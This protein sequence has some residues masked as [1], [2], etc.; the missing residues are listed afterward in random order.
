MDAAVD[1]ILIWRVDYRQGLGG[2]AATQRAT[3]ALPRL[4]LRTARQIRTAAGV[5]LY[6]SFVVALFL[7]VV[8]IPPLIQ[9]APRLRLIDVPNPRKVHTVPVPLCG[10][11]AIAAG[12]LVPVLMWVSLDR[13]ALAYLAG[14][15]TILAVGVYDDARP[16][17]Y[18]WKFAG[19]GVAVALVLAGGISLV[20]LP[21][22]GMDP[23]PQW[24]TW[25]VTALFIV[26]VTNAVNLADG[27][28]GL[29]GGCVLLTLLAVGLLAY[30]TDGALVLV[31]SAAMAGAVL[32][33]LRYNTHP[34]SV[35]LG[36]AGSMFLGFTSAVMAILLVERFHSAL[37]PALP[38]LLVGLPIMD[39][40][41]VFI[42]RLAAGQSPFVADRNHLHHQL[43][44]AGF[45]QMEA[46]SVI[47]LVQAAMVGM[48]LLTRYE[49]DAVV[50]AAFVAI[51]LCVTV[52]LR[53][54]QASGRRLH[55]EPP[56]GQFVE[57]RNTW[58]RRQVWLPSWSLAGVRYGLGAFLC[59]GALAPTAT[60]KDFAVLAAIAAGFWVIGTFLFK[61][62]SMVI[63]RMVMYL[64]AGFSAYLIAS[65]V[66]GDRML[67]WS[68]GVYLALLAGLLVIAIRVTRRELFR[69]TPQDLLILFLALAVPNLSG[70]D[71][72]RYY[73]REVAAI[74]VVLFY[75]SEFI[76]A[77]D[78][79]GRSAIGFA[80]AA[81]LAL[82]GVRG[83]I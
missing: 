4:A 28:D 48:A 23:A 38:L 37:N 58:L 24:L 19:Q 81:A 30:G 68:V 63:V 74:L 49:T 9:L 14:A 32:G 47:Y 53:W 72:A 27:L 65:W 79:H 83:L 2:H 34:A 40:L 31:M 7:T 77:K 66:D 10:G 18:L 26:G 6:F 11:L 1:G 70:S 59:L 46:V 17:H 5:I 75:A 20:H 12:T 76:V 69:V 54:L 16:L 45:K 36:D 62:G 44:A 41:F 39:T 78:E 22:F 52:P 82:I 67:T 33:F 8:A 80:S 64:A 21:F 55:Q 43:L 56:P 51:S 73:A 3:V 60:P 15:L 25:G 57:R 42:R 35:F 71:V 61:L 13:S 50:V 29:A